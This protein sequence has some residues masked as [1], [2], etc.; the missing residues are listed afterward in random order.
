M[1]NNQMKACHT[2]CLIFLCSISKSQRSRQAILSAKY[3]RHLL[4]LQKIRPSPQNIYDNNKYV[5]MYNSQKERGKLLMHMSKETR[6]RSTLT[7][8]V[9]FFFQFVIQKL[10]RVSSYVVLFPNANRCICTQTRLLYATKK[11]KV[12]QLST[13][14]F[15]HQKIKPGRKV[16]HFIQPSILLRLS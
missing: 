6:E 4:L 11:K 1:A 16:L 5:C 8:Q 3:L 15:I 14:N 12:S 9:L 7:N 10:N 2:Y 13:V